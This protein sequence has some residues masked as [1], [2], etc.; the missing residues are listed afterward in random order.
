[1]LIGLIIT[2]SL[3]CPFAFLPKKVYH[4]SNSN[5]S[6]C[7]YIHITPDYGTR[8]ITRMPT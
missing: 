5:K 6:S 2:I 4:V 1:M 7:I 8:I 3:F